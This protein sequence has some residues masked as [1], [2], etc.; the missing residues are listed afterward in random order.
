MITHANKNIINNNFNFFIGEQQKKKTKNMSLKYNDNKH[1]FHIVTSSPWPL[2]TGFSILGLTVSFVAYMHGFYSALFLFFWS[3]VFFLTSLFNWFFD[4]AMEATLEGEHTLK[5]QKMYNSAFLLFLISEF[6]FFITLFW[7]FFH[8]GQEP[9]INIGVTWLPAAIR[10]LTVPHTGLPALLNLLLVMSSFTIEQAHKYLK[11]FNKFYTTLY[12]LV[13]ILL[14]LAFS[15]FQY[16]EYLHTP[17]DFSKTPYGSLLYLL[18]G[19]HGSHVIIGN[20]FLIITLVRILRN[21][22]SNEHHLGFQFAMLYWHFVDFV[23][24]FVLSLMYVFNG[25]SGDH[26]MIQDYILLQEL[27]FE[28]DAHGNLWVYLD[29]IHPNAAEFVRDNN[30]IHTTSSSNLIKIMLP[31]SK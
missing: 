9:N 23:W 13:T 12:L 16:K 5:V 11:Q 25:L 21:H 19:F 24:I 2:Y 6:L 8:F 10:D 30:L 31:N 28:Y 20:I 22:L 29:L 1:P 4:V 7:T 18:T 17:V 3:F 26:R 15:V 27:L 14:G